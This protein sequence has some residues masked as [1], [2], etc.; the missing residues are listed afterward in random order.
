[1]NIAHMVVLVTRRL[2]PLYPLRAFEAA[3]RHRSMSAAARELSLTQSA[4]SHQVKALETHFG[5]ALFRRTRA[6]LVLTRRGQQVFAVARAAFS[7]L[8]ELGT[9]PATDNLSGTVTIAAPPLFCAHWLLPKLDRFART[10]PSVTFR[11]INVTADRPELLREVD[12]AIVWGEGVPNGHHGTKLMPAMQVPVA[13]PALLASIGAAAPEELLQQS[14]ILHEGST[15]MWQGWSERAKVPIAASGHEWVFDDPALVIEACIAGHG[16]ALGTLPLIDQLIT[17][18]ELIALFR[19]PLPAPSHYYLTRP[20]PPSTGPA[21][22]AIFTWLK[23]FS[24][25]E[26]TQDVDIGA[27]KRSKPQIS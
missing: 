27:R 24:D 5:T 11:I 22:A 1:M 9:D 17:N 4:I 25:D 7:D 8:S 13:S 6:G 19:E 12:L 26:S 18:G 10:N 23:E 16:V 2:P 3:A 14:R 15:Q 21:A 20:A